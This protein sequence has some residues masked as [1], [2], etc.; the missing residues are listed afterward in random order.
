MRMVH[1]PTATLQ[2]HMQRKPSKDELLIN[3]LSLLCFDYQF[4]D[5]RPVFRPNKSIGESHDA[6]E[7]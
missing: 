3:L 2:S 5:E 1:Y 7:K 4:R 6:N